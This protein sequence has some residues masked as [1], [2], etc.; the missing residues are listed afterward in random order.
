MLFARIDSRDAADAFRN[1]R[2]A[3]VRHRAR[4]LLTFRETLLRFAN[5]G[6]LPVTNIQRKLLQRRRDDR[7]RR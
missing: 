1:D 7:E 3:L 6:A 2:I 4:T 5:F